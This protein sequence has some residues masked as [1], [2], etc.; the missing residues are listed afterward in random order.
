MAITTQRILTEVLALPED[1]RIDLATELFASV[2][3]TADN[4]WESA[5]LAELDR[6][7][8]ASLQRGDPGDDWKGGA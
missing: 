5:W 3:G 2:D 4:D 8:R 6:R 7:V 1:A